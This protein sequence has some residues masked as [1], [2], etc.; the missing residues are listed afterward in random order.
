[1]NIHQT[2]RAVKESGMRAVISRGL[3]GSGHDEAGQMRLRQA[4]EERTR[5]KTAIG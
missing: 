1:M 4:Y 3:I 2:T 5:Q